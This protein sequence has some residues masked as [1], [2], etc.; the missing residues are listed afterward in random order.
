[1]SNQVTGH[2]HLLI[3]DIAAVA[4]QRPPG[5]IEAVMSA[6]TRTPDG[7][8]LEIDESELDRLRARYGL[9]GSP[10]AAGCG[11]CGS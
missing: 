4:D 2:T 3:G 7:L 1:M 6:G 5:Y 11:G 10:P 8:W 9:P